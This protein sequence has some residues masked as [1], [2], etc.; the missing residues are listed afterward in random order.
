M[1]SV[2]LSF[3]KVKTVRGYEVRKLH[4]GAYVDAID[5]IQGIP[6][7]LI[8]KCF[9]DE[10]G[11]ILAS[12]S[13][14]DANGIVQ[15]FMRVLAVVPEYAIELCAKLLEIDVNSLK[16]D[17]AIGLDGMVELITAWVEVNDIENFIKAVHDL[18]TS[19]TATKSL[20][21]LTSGFSGLL[22]KAMSLVSAKKS[23]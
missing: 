3:P 19:W 11:D 18:K 4:L 15:L 10:N 13:G 16:S 17:R 14:I 5:A 9:S 12:L 1:N 20:P 8:K 7:E 6:T 23:S 22:H 2:K 21:Q